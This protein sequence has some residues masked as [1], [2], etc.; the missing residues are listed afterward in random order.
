MLLSK[1]E[2][3][4]VADLSFEEVEVPEWKGSILLWQMTAADRGD[5]SAYM[6]DE[7]GK[8]KPN[9]MQGWQVRYLSLCIKDSN[10]AKLFTESDLQ[11]LQGKSGKVIERLFGEAQR[12][13]GTS[14]NA[15][16]DAKKD[17]A[18]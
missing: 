17:S 11:D 1:E 5:L 10:G 9:T 7:K 18:G 8:P 2:I 14:E 16:D 15:L 4:K 3:L 12:I 13:N 6:V